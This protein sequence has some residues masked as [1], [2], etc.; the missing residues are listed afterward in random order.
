MCVV[1]P[2]CARPKIHR[3]LD[4]KND[5]S[6][7]LIRTK[8]NEYLTRAEELKNH[9]QDTEEKRSRKAVS[10]NGTANGMLFSTPSRGERYVTCRLLSD[11]AWKPFSGCQRCFSSSLGMGKQVCEWDACEG[12]DAYIGARMKVFM[13]TCEVTSQ[14]SGGVNGLLELHKKGPLA[15]AF[16][17]PT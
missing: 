5:R 11:C 12:R 4:E 14:W 1:L 13:S 6:K 9:I 15:C 7:V 10:A 8:I 16:A 2:S 17:N 3:A